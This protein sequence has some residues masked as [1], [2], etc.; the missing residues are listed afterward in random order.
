MKLFKDVFLNKDV[1]SDAFKMELIDDAYYVFTGKL[2]IR[3]DAIDDA[4]IGGNKSAEAEEGEDEGAVVT[5]ATESNLIGSANLDEAMIA[6]KKDFKKKISAYGKK[7]M[8]H[9][10]E[11]NPERLDVFKAG[12]V[13]V[14]KMFLEKFDDIVVYSCEEDGYDFEGMLIIHETINADSKKGDQPDDICKL[15][16]FKDGVYEEKC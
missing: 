13:K 8:G 6:D 14:V 7:L 16:V 15:Y 12:M 11:N 4:L 1:C 5:K 2:Q 3:S 9:L 10:Q